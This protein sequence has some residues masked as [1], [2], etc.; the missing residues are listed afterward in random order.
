MSNGR[1]VERLNVVLDLDRDRDRQLKDA[2]DRLPDGTRMHL[3]RYV[4]LK[5]IPEL[6][7]G[8]GWSELLAEAMR[9]DV[10]RGRR[11]GRQPGS[12]QTKVRA[13]EE[14]GTVESAPV[15][16]QVAV[17]ASVAEPPPLVVS[18]T[19]APSPETAEGFE[20]TPSQVVVESPPP[21]P[22]PAPATLSPRLSRLRGMGMGTTR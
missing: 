8:D 1:H 3:C 20:A 10:G 2:L 21:V 4:L 16:Q 18:T 14:T 17:A 13:V 9:D 22:Q 6:E 15:G 11:R 12:G 19:K 5:F 7:Q